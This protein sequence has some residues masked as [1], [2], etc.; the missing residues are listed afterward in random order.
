MSSLV[1]LSFLPL[2]T[3]QGGTEMVKR[4]ILFPRMPQCLSAAGASGYGY[5]K[6]I[7]RQAPSD[8]GHTGLWVCA[9]EAAPYVFWFLRFLKTYFD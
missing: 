3:S 7:K 6:H 8:P 5:R 9:K 4:E 2:D 1:L